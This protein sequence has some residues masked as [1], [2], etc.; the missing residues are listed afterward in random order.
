MMH[1][2]VQFMLTV[3]ACSVLTILLKR[4]R[5]KTKRRALHVLCGFHLLWFVPNKSF[6]NIFCTSSERTVNIVFKGPHISQTL[7]ASKLYQNNVIVRFLVTEESRRKI[8][9]PPTFDALEYKFCTFNAPRNGH[10][11][12]HVR[13]LVINNITELR[14]STEWHKDFPC[15]WTI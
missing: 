15:L 6:D 14:I 12:K 7:A 2:R 9:P 10:L 1:V 5:L 3:K 11:L 13:I 8:R 4:E